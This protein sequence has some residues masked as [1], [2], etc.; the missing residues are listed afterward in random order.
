MDLLYSGAAL[1]DVEKRSREL[2]DK[3]SAYITALSKNDLPAL[4]TILPPASSSE[5][6]L[7][8]WKDFVK[9]NGPLEGFEILGTSPLNQQQGV[10]TFVRLQF[11]KHAGVYKVT[12]RNQNLWQQA[13]D[14]L[15]PEITSFLRKS[16]VDFPLTVSFLPQSET[17]FATYD[18][19]KGQTVSLTF[20]KSEKLL[21]H[22]KSGDIEARKVSR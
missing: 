15:Q 19:F 3:T 20:P 7:R 14:R 11:Q 18:L 13:E 22:T 21:I 9:Q 12:W 4:K 8:R 16:F 1:P 17:D 2:N 6:T 10:Q 5:E